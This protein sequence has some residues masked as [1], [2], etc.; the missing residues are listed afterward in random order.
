M[1]M[2]FLTIRFREEEDVWRQTE[3]YY[4]E[5]FEQLEQ[6]ISSNIQHNNHLSHLPST[7]RQE[8]M[9]LLGHNGHGTQHDYLQHERQR[10][11]SMV[12]DLDGKVMTKVC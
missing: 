5:R 9:E 12:H 11:H 8:W 6:Q 2:T 10:L 1:S 4:E 7:E 3:Q